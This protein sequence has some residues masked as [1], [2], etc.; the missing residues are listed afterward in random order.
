MKYYWHIFKKLH[1]YI[2]IFIL[3]LPSFYSN[4]QN[5]PVK[6]NG[7][8]KS[9][10]NNIIDQRIENIAEQL[11]NENADYTNLIDDM[12]Y[13][14]EHPLRLN[15]A[16]KQQLEDFGLLDEIQINSLLNHLERNGKLMTIYELQSVEGFDLQT[17]KKILPYISIEDNFQTPNLSLSELLNNGQH[18]VFM[19][20]GQII[21]KQSGFMPIT[22][23]A[24]KAS[25]NS[26]YLGDPSKLFFRYRYTYG[27]NVSWG[28]TAEKD[29]GEEFFKGAQKNGFDFYSAH[30]F[31]RNIG[32]IKALA[33]GD[34][35]LQTGQGVVFSSGLAF[36]KTSDP[37]NI[38][39]NYTGLRA[40]NSVNENVFLRGA[41]IT[42][43][44][45]KKINVTVFG[46]RKKLDGNIINNSPSDSLG[47]DEQAIV[48]SFQLSGF[49]RTPSELE[50]RKSVDETIY[51]AYTNYQTRNFRVGFTYVNTSYSATLNRTGYLYNKYYFSGKTNANM[52]IEYN[53]VWRNMNFFGEAG[54][55]ANGGMAMV[56]GI[57]FSL[58]PKL[59]ASIH[60]RNYG[61]TYQALMANA[62]G[63]NTNIQNEKGLYAGISFKPITVLQLNSYFDRFE[64]PWLKYQ[65]N[66]PS[67][68]YDFFFQTTYTPNK[69]IYMYARYRNREKAK[70]TSQDIDDIDFLVT[71]NQSNYRYEVS[72]TVSPSVK[73]KNRIELVS[74]N[75]SDQPTELG[76]M[77][78]QDLSYREMN[79]PYSF[80]FRYALFD[81]KSYN[82]RIYAYESDVLY[83][84][85]VP[86]YSGKGARTYIVFKYALGRNIDIWLR[87]AQF[88]YLNT[89]SIGSGLTETEGNTKSD[90]RI[91]IRY[92]F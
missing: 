62:L 69:K 15:S 63:E 76:Y 3:T 64:F 57:L 10:Q 67:N 31:V 21:E 90:F 80:S 91:Q 39:R 66:A 54:R 84:Y 50:G 6:E 14:Q 16:N 42:Y 2:F 26:R 65:L 22:D 32:K 46:S 24:L 4:G 36:G 20:Y 68:G 12:L 43:Q 49:H 34:Y 52:G 17:I 83:A 72:Y 60:Y 28:I 75:L 47:Q 25:P 9:D 38:K 88:Y 51:G 92:R 70:N 81:T 8:L 35:Q 48:S 87:A 61:R 30:L 13:Y 79:K 29:P 85:S 5:K 55:S 53:Y 37:I 56:Q 27:N 1:V 74:Y 86:A 59:N 19:R 7:E 33:L 23:S 11:E 77:F 40:Y 71:L 89:S 58:D 45:F 82:S 41:A 18:S 73:L 78:Y 44:F